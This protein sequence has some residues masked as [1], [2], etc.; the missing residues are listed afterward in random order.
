M[1]IIL[2]GLDELEKFA[3]KEWKNTPEKDFIG[4]LKDKV[5][6][7]GADMNYRGAL[8]VY[9]DT[10]KYIFQMQYLS[11]LDHEWKAPVGSLERVRTLEG[12]PTIVNKIAARKARKVWNYRLKFKHRSALVCLELSEILPD[13]QRAR[14]NHE[15]KRGIKQ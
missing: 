12:N 14:I 7:I 5:G 15:V 10:I 8:E 9:Q 13:I 3:F 4:Y 6:G 11:N 1:K 2:D